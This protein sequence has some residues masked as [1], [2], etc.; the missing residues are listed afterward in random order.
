MVSTVLKSLHLQ[1]K[2]KVLLSTNT[3]NLQKYL[4]KSAD[5]KPVLS[6][7]VR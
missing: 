3:K 7:A 1:H 2:L 5:Q 4:R 6:F